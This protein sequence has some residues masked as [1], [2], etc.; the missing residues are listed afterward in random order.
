MPPLFYKSKTSAT[1]KQ[2]KIIAYTDTFYLF[3]CLWQSNSQSGH[4]TCYAIQSF[5]LWVI[6]G[7]LHPGE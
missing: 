5:V 7:F 4:H 1:N 6:Y 2:I 3:I